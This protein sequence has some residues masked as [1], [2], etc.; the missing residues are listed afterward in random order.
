MIFAAMLVAQSTVYAFDPVQARQQYDA[1]CAECHGSDGRGD[2]PTALRQKTKPRD[3]TN[4]DLMRKISDKKMFEVI[5]FGG[6]D[7]GM[8]PDMPAWKYVFTDDEIK[9]L[10]DRIHRFCKGY[11]GNSQP[12]HTIIAAYRAH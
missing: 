9:G 12:R 11:A 8:S 3:F 10:I 1:Y 7:N 6:Y 5:K 2:G 4:C